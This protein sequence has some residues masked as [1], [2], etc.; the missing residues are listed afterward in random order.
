MTTVDLG[1]V[2]DFVKGFK[3]DKYAEGLAK[4]KEGEIAK[5]FKDKL[6]ELAGYLNEDGRFGDEAVRFQVYVKSSFD[7]K[8]GKSIYNVQ[9]S[10]V[11]S[12][13]QPHKIFHYISAGRKGR[14]TLGYTTFPNGHKVASSFTQN[15]QGYPE[16]ISK[17]PAAFPKN[18]DWPESSARTSGKRF[19]LWG[20]RKSKLREWFI[21]PKGK[22]MGG[23]FGRG[24]Y[25]T[26]FTELK[27]AK[28][29]NEI[30]QKLGD[31]DLK[32][33]PAIINDML[34]G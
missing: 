3:P 31:A 29:R 32:F 13:G 34:G 14:V 2:I 26:I 16:A 12:S 30:K 7:F 27:D 11:N 20:K 4:R 1:D 18:E 8:K 9:I 22:K 23:W 5:V 10:A 21:Y 6:N 24:L 33:T 17:K 15:N 19:H 25:D 28:F